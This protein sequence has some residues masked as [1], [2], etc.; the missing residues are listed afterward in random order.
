ML[1]LS[2]K[3]EFCSIITT[4]QRLK[5]KKDRMLLEGLRVISD[6]KIFSE[7]I[8]L[9]KWWIVRKERHLSIFTAVE[10]TIYKRQFVDTSK[11]SI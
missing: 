7:I 10:T 9:S 1:F 8:Q 2:K 6:R 11:D 4:P 3:T 5:I